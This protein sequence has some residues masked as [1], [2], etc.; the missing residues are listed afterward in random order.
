MEQITDENYCTLYL[1]RHGETEWNNKSITQGQSE[2]VLT[3][4]GI[5]QAEVTAVNLKDI[6]FDAIFSSDLIRTQETAKIIKLDRDIVIQTSRLLRE[7]N[8]GRF[9]G[10]HSSEFREAL[11]E[12]LDKEKEVLRS[13]VLIKK[14]VKEVKAR[15][16]RKPLMTTDAVPG[17]QERKVHEK[18]NPEDFG[19]YSL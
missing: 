11:K 6:H 3:Q 12:K 13:I 2:S 15:R 14:A 9:E 16:T 17:L 7:R 8:Y 1:V 4:T 5:E 18:I 10:K 19:R